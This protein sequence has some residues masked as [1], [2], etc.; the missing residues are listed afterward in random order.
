MA[1]IRKRKKVEKK[2]TVDFLH[3]GGTLFNL[4]A[5]QRA[6]NGGIP[7]GRVTNLVGDGSSGEEQATWSRLKYNSV[8]IPL[9]FMPSV[10]IG[11]YPVLPATVPAGNGSIANAARWT[12]HALHVPRHNSHA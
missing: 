4:A 9:F 1:K 7:R 10:S 11:S 3:S 12:S 5:S 2:E 8:R 6:A